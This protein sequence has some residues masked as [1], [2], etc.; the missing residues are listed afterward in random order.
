MNTDTGSS[1]SY[2]FNSILTD[3]Q[4]W[5]DTA[6][7]LVETAYKLENEKAYKN[8]DIISSRFRHIYYMLIGFALEN[9]YKGAI[10]T[11][12]LRNH[13]SIL[14]DKLDLSIKS[15]QLAEL[16]R[17]AGII[18]EGRFQESHISYITECIIWKGRYPLPTSA[19]SIDGSMTCYPGEERK[20]FTQLEPII[21]ISAVHELI[22]QAQSNLYKC[23][24]DNAKE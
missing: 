24:I 17:D 5:N 6:D 15:H 22:E 3:I 16:A 14:T 9:Y 20:V 12:R 8:G 21:T 13:E 2:T 23:V 7:A 4:F 11:K 19:N 18:F 10:L 1:D